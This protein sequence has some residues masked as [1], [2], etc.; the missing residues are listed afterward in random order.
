LDYTELQLVNLS[1]ALD[2]AFLTHD[3]FTM[4]VAKTRTGIVLSAEFG[5]L[6]LKSL[7]HK[8]VSLVQATYGGGKVREV[9]DLALVERPGNEMLLAFADS[10]GASRIRMAA[11]MLRTSNFD[12]VL[13]E[14]AWKKILA[15]PEKRLQV[16]VLP[17]C[18]KW[19]VENVVERARR[20]VGPPLA[21]G[22]RSFTLDATIQSAE[23]RHA[24]IAQFKLELQKQSVVCELVVEQSDT[25]KVDDFLSH[26]HQCI[27]GELPHHCVFLVFVEIVPKL[28]AR[29]THLSE[30]RFDEDD[31]HHWVDQIS[32]DKDWP[33]PL[34]QEFKDWLRARACA[35]QAFPHGSVYEAIN[36]AVSILGTNPSHEELR[37][38]MASA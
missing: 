6:G 31:L 20:C 32:A 17:G 26:L 30:L 23:K 2:K 8:F 27:P 21:A 12:L 22:R 10:V 18:N 35:D 16:F 24:R 34:K 37:A 4:F 36:D 13:T 14:H 5:D 3:A 7:A 28:Q 19:L 25:D 33:A 9:I 15:R 1:E 29:C 38:H 11:E